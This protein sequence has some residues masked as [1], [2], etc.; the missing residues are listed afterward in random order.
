VRHKRI[1]ARLLFT[2]LLVTIGAGPART[3]TWQEESTRSIPIL[4]IR[5]LRIENARGQI[6][7]TRAEGSEIRLTALKVVRSNDPKWAKRVSAGTRV[8]AENRGGEYSVRV[9][10][11]QRQT[12]KVRFWDLLSDFE[13]P[14]VEIR[15]ALDVPDGIAVSLKS[16]SGDLAS[17]GIHN[18]QLIE[19]T[20]GDVSVT[21][22]SAV[23]ANTTSGDVH[24]V[25]S[26]TVRVRTVSGDLVAERMRGALSATTTSGNVSVR[27]SEDSL[28]VSTVSGDITIDAAPRGIDVGTTSGEVSVRR[29]AGRIAIESA[30]GD[31]TVGLEAPLSPSRIVTVNGAVVLRL[32]GTIACALDLRTS[33]GE[34][35][36]DVPLDVEN[37][38]RHQLKAVVRKGTVPVSV[39]TASG[40]ISVSE[41]AR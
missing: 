22:A 10:Y 27:G 32:I 41:G 30:S 19:S 31:V 26:G 38:T 8:V 2:I 23:R 4:G 11:P 7:I 1:N 5:S 21:E 36:I 6:S 39:R 17:T 24:V 18:A 37:V 33:N 29:A 35:Q 9:V 40:D 3:E 28:V 34:I 13:L 14:R 25:D 16:T 20:S 15:L 12:V